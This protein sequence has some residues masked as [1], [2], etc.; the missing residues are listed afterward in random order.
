MGGMFI[1]GYAAIKTVTK[2][3]EAYTT[4]GGIVDETMNDIKSI[5]SANLQDYCV[6]KYVNALLP[7]ERV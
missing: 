4:A 2:L 3:Q 1:V 5:S 7:T 6:E